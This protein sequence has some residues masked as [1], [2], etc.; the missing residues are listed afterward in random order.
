M[1]DVMTRAQFT[2]L[3]QPGLDSI[4]NDNLGKREL[5]YKKLFNIKTSKRKN[6]EDYG[7]MSLGRFGTKDEGGI[8]TLDSLMAGYYKQYTNLTYAKYVE[9]TE[10]AI[11]DD[12]YDQLQDLAK[13]MAVSWEESLEYYH[14]YMLNYCSVTTY[15]AGGDTFALQ[16]DSHLWSASSAQ[17][18]DT[19]AST[20]A[21]SATA[22]EA[23]LVAIRGTKDATGKPIWLTPR[24]IWSGL[25][26]EGP[27]YRVL[28]A[29]LLPGTSQNDPNALKALYRL[30]PVCTPYITST[31]KWGIQ[32]DPHF[33][34][35]YM[36]KSFSTRAEVAE[37][38]GNL[39]WY[40]RGRFVPG[41][42]Y[43]VGNYISTGA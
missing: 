14:W 41:F 17:T 33:L 32:C 21:F 13:Q 38:T 2:R 7:V 29:T 23:A 10:E 24:R 27:I 39:R 40:G 18:Y 26:L 1:A 4:V 15:Y 34:K 3:Y 30:E 31:T 42:N 25:T 11:E 37:G 43:A 16:Y 35:S 9:I 22:L 6:E 36:R 8:V 19:D 12:L 5:L 20:T 28:N